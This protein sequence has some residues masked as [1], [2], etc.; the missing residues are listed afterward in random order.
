MNNVGPVVH[1]TSLQRLADVA[2]SSEVHRT[3]I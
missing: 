2:P 1:W 3:I